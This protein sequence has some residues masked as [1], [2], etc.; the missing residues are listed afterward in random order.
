VRSG[1]RATLLSPFGPD[2]LLAFT[3]NKPFNAQRD[4]NAVMADAVLT[5]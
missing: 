1:R 2:R 3:N 4:D 5:F